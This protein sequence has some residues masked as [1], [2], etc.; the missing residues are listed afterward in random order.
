MFILLIYILGFIATLWVF[1][2]S[3]NSGTEI[4]L[5]DLSLAIVV[6]GFSWFGFI[7]LILVMYGDET[8]FKKE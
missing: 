6:C 5:N 4:T 1:Y 2:R 8:I 7:I 3:L